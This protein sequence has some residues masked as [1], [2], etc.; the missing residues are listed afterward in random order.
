MHVT[1]PESFSPEETPAPKQ[2]MCAWKCLEA[3]PRQTSLMGFGADSL[4]W[5]TCGQERGEPQGLTPQAFCSYYGQTEEGFPHHTSKHSPE[6]TCVWQARVLRT[7]VMSIYGSNGTC[8]HTV[9]TPALSTCIPTGLAQTQK[10]AGEL[11]VHGLTPVAS[12]AS[13]GPE[14]NGKEQPWV[15]GSARQALLV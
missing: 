13:S 5:T 8:H 12:T 1:R 2:H 6:D 7:G 11:T 3:L 9:P 14:D 15:L 10:C 4:E